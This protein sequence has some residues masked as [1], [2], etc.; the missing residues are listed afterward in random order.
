MSRPLVR[1]LLAIPLTGM[2]LAGSLAAAWLALG[3]PQPASGAPWMTVHRLGTEAAKQACRL[4]GRIA[5]AFFETR[6][7]RAPIRPIPSAI[8]SWIRR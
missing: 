7:T 8:A 3:S 1:L 5:L 6:S 2:L 4:P